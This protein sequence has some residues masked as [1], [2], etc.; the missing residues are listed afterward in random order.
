MAFGGRFEMALKPMP[1][2]G[3][4]MIGIQVGATYYSYGDAYWNYKYIPIG[5]TANYHFKLA[6]SKLDPFVGAGLGYEI[7]TCGG[8]GLS[9]FSCGATSAIYYIGRAGVRYFVT[10][11]LA[12]YADA[13]AGGALA[14]VGVMLRLK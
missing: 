8:T 2:L 12:L 7:I 10:P 3:G 9:G 5:V 13:G 6:D 11:K 14:N 1:Q 4:G